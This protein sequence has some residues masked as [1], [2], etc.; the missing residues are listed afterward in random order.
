MLEYLNDSEGQMID[1]SMVAQRFAFSDQSHLIRYLKK[2]LG[3]TPGQ[4]AKLRDFTIDVYGDFE[5]P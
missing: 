4:Y 2:N 3:E 1:W 5:T